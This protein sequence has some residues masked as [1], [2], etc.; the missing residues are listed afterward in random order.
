M[1]L[2]EPGRIGEEEILARIFCELRA[3]FPNL[4]LII[5]PRHTE[6]AGEIRRELEQLGLR[7]A[8]RTQSAV[9]EV[10]VDC[11]LLDSTGELRNWYSIATVVFIGKSLMAHGGQNP[12]EAITAGKPIVFGP[13]M[14]NFKEIADTFL[15]NGAAVQVAS[16]RELETA[17]VA[18]VTDPVRRA[19]LGA[20][21]RALV[22]ANRG[23]KDKTL[24]VLAD[25]EPP[26]AAVASVR[27]FR[28]V[29]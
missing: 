4:F 16:N 8:L 24:T 9:V 10:P 5:A 26:S 13:H 21:A 14:Q 7:V 19:R 18:L 15:T 25:L 6:R 1:E 11:L 22:D 20:A 17:L 12:A 28:L 27:P 3:H 29:H 2:H 23:A